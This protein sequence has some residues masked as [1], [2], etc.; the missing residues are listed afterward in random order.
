MRLL[1]NPKAVGGYTGIFR[2]GAECVIG[3]FSL[4]IKPTTTESIPG[5][6]L[7]IFIDGDQPSLNMHLLHSLD[8]QAGQNYFAQ[9]FSN[10]LPQPNGLPGRVI[11]NLFGRSAEQFGAKDPN[12]GRLTLEHIAGMLPNGNRIQLPKAPYQ[13]LYKPT[14]RAHEL[15]QGVGTE[16]DFRI[17]LAKL[18]VGQVL[19]DIYTL[20]E[21]APVENA[22]FLGQLILTSQ[23][24]SSH[25][26][27]EKL[28]FQHNM[29][30]K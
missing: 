7:K 3:R 27:D 30:R 10:I 24:V 29:Q 28:Y 8:P 19:Y 9:T 12:P 15:M 25:Y 2:S 20:A 13:L 18:P 11:S 16:E 23:V 26:G 1:I 6:A 17:K 14:A 5:L 21:S 4:A 22:S